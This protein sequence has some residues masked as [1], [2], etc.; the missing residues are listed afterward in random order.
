MNPDYRRV[1]KARAASYP[2][3]HDGC[4]GPGNHRHEPPRPQPGGRPHRCGRGHTRAGRPA[5]QGRGRVRPHRQPHAVHRREAGRPARVDARGRGRRLRPGPRRPGGLGAH[6]GSA[7]RR[8]P[9][10]LPRPGPGTPGRGARP[11]PAGDRQGPP[12]RPRGGPGRRGGRPALRPQGP[13]LPARQ[14]AHRRRTDPDQGHRAAPP[15]RRRRPDRPVELPAGAVRRRRAP[16]LRRGQR[17][18]HEARHRDLP[19][20]PV[21]P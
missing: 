12:A 15:A 2:A 5:H 18:G 19:D 21:G 16:R 13:R 4:A 3:A 1:H 10:P 17:G 11:H 9:A 6:P 14:A 20:R 7:A 8:R